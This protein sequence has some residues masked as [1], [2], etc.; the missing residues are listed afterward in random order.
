MWRAPRR[1]ASWCRSPTERRAPASRSW[2]CSAT[3]PG[4]D[5][6][7]V[8][9]QVRPTDD[10]QQ[11]LAHVSFGWEPDSFYREWAR[12]P[13]EDGDLEELRGPG[14]MRMTTQ[15]PRAAE[16]LEL[17]RSLLRSEEYRAR[18]VRHY[19]M[20]R[21]VIDDPSKSRRDRSRDGAARRV[22]VGGSA[23]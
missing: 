8:V 14:L 7:R 21:A 1:D 3:S 5:C 4:C 15:S 10:L 23:E 18:I 12:F 20:F 22:S 11:V 9:L 2:R 17:A 16:V 6:R 13:L 19:E